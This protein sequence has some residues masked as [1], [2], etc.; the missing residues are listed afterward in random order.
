MLTHS[1]KWL[2]MALLLSWVAADA[3]WGQWRI[4]APNAVQPQIFGGAI[5]FCDGILHVSGSSSQ[6]GV[7]SVL[8]NSSDTGKTW[9]SVN[10]P[11][12]GICDISFYDRN[13]GVVCCS[14]R[15][16]LTHDGGLTWIQIFQ[17][18]SP[19]SR[20]SFDGSPLIIHLI[21]TMP[22]CMITSTDGG[23]TWNTTKLGADGGLG[24][25]VGKSGIVYAFSTE[26]ENTP[27]N[28]WV[29]L[30]T[31]FGQTWSAPESPIDG[32]SYTISIDSCNEQRLYLVNEDYYLPSDSNS[33]IFV[34]GDA[35]QTWQ[36]TFIHPLPYIAGSLANSRNVIFIPTTSD[37]VLR[38]SDKGM[39]WINTGG[40]GCA[41]DSRSICTVNDD[42]AFVLEDS[43]GSVWATYNSGGYPFS[44][45]SLF[46]ASP[47]TLFQSDMISCDS[48]SQ[49]AVFS[50]NGC[51]F[52]SVTGWS[53]IGVDSA[54]YN[55]TNLFTDSIVVTFH[56]D[57]QGP[58][59]AQLLLSLDDGATDTISLAGNVNIPALYL[60]SSGAE[61]FSSDTIYCDSL[62]RSI[63]FDR[64]GCSSLSVSKYTI[65]GGDSSSFR[66]SNVFYDSLSVTFRGI[67]QGNQQAQLILLLN[68]GLNDT[69]QLGGYANLIPA[70]LSFSTQD[71][72]TDTLGATVAVPITINGLK[73]P[74]DVDLIL[75]YDGTMDYLGSFSP[76]G[77]K[78]DIAGEQWAGRSE[79][80]IPG[81]A[82]GVVAGYAKFNV[83]NDSSE[84]AHASF[85]S[86]NVLTAISPCE[87]SLPEAVTSTITAPSGCGIT[88]L[89]QFVHLGV[90]PT[91]SIRPNPANGD[92]WISSSDDIGDVTFAIYDMLGVE[93]GEIVASVSKDNVVELTLPQADGVY[94][95]VA[96]YSNGTSMMRVVREHY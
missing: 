23:T 7:T 67:N 8:L 29:N 53:F 60:T 62:T 73:R 95:I 69:V 22:D 58:H 65:I 19:L 88:I 17:L 14:D 74:E 93:R 56:A 4:M 92:V 80:N 77:A 49:S 94:N 66:V 38:S 32:D 85:D 2:W 46:S 31:D 18:N 26:D 27:N 11:G 3:A 87:Y 16:F 36:Q 15:L 70:A 57:K 72:K 47:P 28:G 96:K 6:T 52:L 76:V 51:P 34:S 82:P 37:G 78:L 21:V 63:A 91:F 61:L 44:S 25:A 1:R 10:F 71:V 84:S 40:P 41:V 55:V 89:S 79:L 64:D 13:T 90:V 35:G 39:T 54:S 5:N 43:T 42:I 33:H 24:F 30:S 81:A 20:V 86:V 9:T 83:F 75:H 59:N 45:A 12:F 50:R 48:I 68:N